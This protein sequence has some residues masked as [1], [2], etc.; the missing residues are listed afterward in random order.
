MAIVTPILMLLINL[1]QKDMDAYL[2]TRINNAKTT[3]EGDAP[4]I[5]ISKHFTYDSINP[6]NNWRAASADECM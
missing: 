5:K 1:R 6:L 3:C 2:E 4:T